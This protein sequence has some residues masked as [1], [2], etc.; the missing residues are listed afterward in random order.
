MI[1][2]PNTTNKIRV[3]SFFCCFFRH[4]YPT[5]AEEGVM[6]SHQIRLP[7]KES[8]PHKCHQTNC[9]ICKTKLFLIQFLITSISFIN[10]GRLTRYVARN[11]FVPRVLTLARTVVNNE[12]GKIQKAMIIL[13]H[14]ERYFANMSRKIISWSPLRCSFYKILRTRQFLTYTKAEI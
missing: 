2:L 8:I 1:S 6:I 3:Q 11:C 4:S 10:W 14:L 12:G 13:E 5:L 7:K 9:K